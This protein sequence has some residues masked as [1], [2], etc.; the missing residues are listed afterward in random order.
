MTLQL[1]IAEIQAL[2]YLSRKYVTFNDIFNVT[3]RLR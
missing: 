1:A 2:F 3:D